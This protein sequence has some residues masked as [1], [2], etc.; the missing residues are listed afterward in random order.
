M[1]RRAI[2]AAL[3]LC[4]GGL[5]ALAV[6]SSAGRGGHGPAR[7][8][9][10]DRYLGRVAPGTR[11][12]FGLSLRMRSAALERYATAVGAGARPPLTA[13]QIGERFG[14][15]TTAVDHVRGLLEAAGVR[16]E[17]AFKQRTQILVS[18]PAA[19]AERLL[20]VPL[21][22]FRD[23]RGGHYHRPLAQPVIPPALRSVVWAAT[24]LDTKRIP[25]SE[26]IPANG[27]TGHDLAAL[28][29]LQPLINQGL[30]GTG[31]TV[32]VFSEDTFLESDIEAFDL[33]HNIVG[34]PK[35]ER[36]EVE[37][38]RV[39]GRRV[40]YVSGSSGSE[41]DLDTEVIR[42]LAP[43][44][45]IINYEIA[46]GSPED[47]IKG[48]DRIVEDGKAKLVNFSYGYCEL[49]FNF[50]QLQQEDKNSFDAAKIANVTVFV[51]SGDQG[52]YECQRY[53]PT[54]HRLSVPWPA[55]SP[56]V[57]SVGGTYVD[58]R[59]DGTRLDEV[60]W[61]EILSRGGGGGGVSA[62]FPRPSWQTGVK[63]IDNQYTTNPPHRQV[64]DV[65]ADAS[66]SSG[67]ASYAHGGD[68]QAGGTSAAAPF[69]T[70][71]FVLIDQLAKR[72]T[73]H[74]LPFIA[75]LLYKAAA[76]DP[77]AFYD[78]T[79]GGNRFYR[80]GP[81]WDYSTGLGVPDMAVLAQDVIAAAGGH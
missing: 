68:E 9:S 29:D 52:A 48:I 15:S 4:L 10:R 41:V 81:G 44:A 50:A 30:D 53:D 34:A 47:F 80:A 60:G 35:I 49:L 42:E 66:P 39:P 56:N 51:S 1:R 3:L 31:Q 6:G 70:G 36:V 75:P 69:W 5:A 20:G 46:N 24:Q 65:A 43:K 32:A 73:G 18:A 17:Q 63:G 33:K 16:V 26:D 25:L 67:Y 11:V 59:K 54:D 22:E 55:S 61:E 2:I 62:V 14:I 72:K 28:Y 23:A 71:S 58:V 19:R 57:V 79:L 45:K 76:R 8:G 74:L 37:D 78:V 13:A 27:M 77:A 40:P 64:P 21:G 7:A 38:H 12:W